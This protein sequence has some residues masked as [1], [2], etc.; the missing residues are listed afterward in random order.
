LSI[1][2]GKLS[3]KVIIDNVKKIKQAFPSLPNG[4][5]DILSDRLKNCN[6]SDERI[7]DAVNNVIDNCVY[8]QPTIA[9]FISFDRRIKLYTYEEMINKVNGFGV[10][11][12]EDYQSVKFPDRDKPVWVSIDDI[13]KYHLK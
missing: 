10:K 6:F 7:N 13:K 8:P 1:Y 11:V 5:Y 12:W 2:S 9:Q 4:F 3:T